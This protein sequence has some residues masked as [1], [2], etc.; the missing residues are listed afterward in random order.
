MKNKFFILFLVFLVVLLSS[1]LC[2]QRKEKSST[3][4]FFLS[5][6]LPGLGERYVQSKGIRDYL[7]ISEI[8]MW[9]GYIGFKTYSNWLKEDYI[10]FAV[11]HA[12]INK[13]GKSAQY[14]VDIGNF[15][16]IYDYNH[17][18]RIQRDFN[19]LYP[20]DS[21]YF[22]EW[23]SR[24][25]RKK[26]EKLRI[27]CDTYKNRKIFFISGA[28]LNRLISGIEAVYLLRK[29]EKSLNKTHISVEYTKSKIAFK[30]NYLF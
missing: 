15:N 16:N 26:F 19:V 20:V 21:D 22:W 11:N 30:L 4:A 10:N 3:K 23:D 7:L 25:N 27:R 17:I 5:I 14:Y 28:I 24:E 9:S 18:K 12:K 2:A 6:I 13:N 8:I 29:R 1:N